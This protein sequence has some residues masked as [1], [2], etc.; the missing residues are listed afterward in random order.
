MALRSIGWVMDPGLGMEFA[1]V[2]ITPR[3]MKATGVAIGTSPVP[4]R[5]DYRFESRSRF[6]TRS[7]ELVSR[8][9]GWRRSLRLER[10]K[11]GEWDASWESHGEALLPPPTGDLKELSGS[12]DCD[13]ALSPLTNTMPVLRHDL[14]H[15]G[16]PVDLL[17]AWISVPDLSIV[18]S[19]QRYTFVRTDELISV[20]RYESSSRDFV[21]DIVFDDDGLVLEYPG[22]GHRIG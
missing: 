11:L 13:L 6:V 14:L 20:V 17:M 19:R 9:Q 10:D 4:Y 15:R 1:E 5:L 22:I 21:A 18:P 8:G 7:I 16:G 3:R 12:L 2:D